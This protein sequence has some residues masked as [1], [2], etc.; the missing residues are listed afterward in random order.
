M[1]SQKP[2]RELGDCPSPAQPQAKTSSCS[3]P[4]PHLPALELARPGGCLTHLYLIQLTP[5]LSNPQSRVSIHILPPVCF[6]CPDPHHGL[7]AAACAHRAVSARGGTR[8][9][10]SLGS[11]SCT[12]L[13]PATARSLLPSTP[14]VDEQSP[15]HTSCC[16]LQSQRDLEHVRGV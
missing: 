4:V 3:H 11:L 2:H 1:T 15:L 16:G 6:H 13:P 8:P 10:P 5:N 14:G 7:G 12:Q 9:C